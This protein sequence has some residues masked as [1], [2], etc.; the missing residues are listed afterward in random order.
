MWASSVR[1]A[2]SKKQAERDDDEL[3]RRLQDEAREVLV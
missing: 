1:K 2:E 3:L